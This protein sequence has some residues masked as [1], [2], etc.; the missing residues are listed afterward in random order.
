M[1]DESTSSIVHSALSTYS[2]S[3]VSELPRNEALM[4][5]IRRQRTM[6]TADVDG[7]LPDKLRKT[8]RGED[9]ILHKE[10]DLIIFTTKINLSILRQY[11]HWF[12]DE[13]FKVN[14]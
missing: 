5:M 14:F 8:Y 11:K 6:E 4:P 7:R 3:A 13:T 2:L 9:F 12:A 10:K 1:T